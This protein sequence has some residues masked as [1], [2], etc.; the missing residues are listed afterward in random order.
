MRKNAKILVKEVGRCSTRGD[1]RECTL[2]SPPQKAEP[3]LALKTRG[4]VTRNQNRDTS[5]PKI[6]HAYVSAKNFF[7]K[8]I[9][10]QVPNLKRLIPLDWKTNSTDKIV[11]IDMLNILL[12]VSIDLVHF[13]CFWL[14]CSSY[15][16][17]FIPDVRNVNYMMCHM[18]P[19]GG[20]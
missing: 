17:S 19:P 15:F 20:S 16:T 6:G 14:L 5:G 7:Q 3:T 9:K 18:S 11:L 13:W 2:H 8:K 10:I 4:D 12:S 1:P